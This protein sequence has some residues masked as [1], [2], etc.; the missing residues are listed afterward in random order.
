MENQNNDIEGKKDK[1]YEFVLRNAA[2][3]KLLASQN[4]S[5]GLILKGKPV[6]EIIHELEVHQIELEMQN[7]QMKTTLLAL[8]E[9]KEKYRDLYDFAPIGYLSITQSGLVLEANFAATAMLRVELKNLINHGF[10]RLISRKHLGIWEHLLLNIFYDFHNNSCELEMIRPNGTTFYVLLNCTQL[11]VSNNRKLAMISI[12]NIDDLK[13]SEADL[14]VSEEK[15]R[16]LFEN[17]IDGIYLSTVEGKFI[18]ANRALV[19]LLGY[20]SKA[21]LLGVDIPN[22]IYATKLE[23]PDSEGKG[24]PYGATFRKKD[25]S[26]IDVEISSNVTEEGNKPK[27]YQGIVR[28]ITVRKK[29]D[30]KLRY[31]S[32]HDSLTGLY[33]RAYFR[34]ELER[35]DNKRQLPISYILGDINGLKLVNDTIGHHAGDKLLITVANLL[36]KYFRSEDVVARWGG[37]EFAIILPKTTTLVVEQILER[38]K[39]ACVKK[40]SIKDLPISISFGIFTK[41]D[42]SL[43]VETA[44]KLAETNMYKNKLLEKRSSSSAVI[45][46]IERMMYEKSYE[47]EEHSRRLVALSV[48]LG[49]SIKLSESA[50]NDLAIF[51]ELHDIGKIAIP[52]A[53]LLKKDKLTDKE[54]DIVKR[55]SE[56]GYNIARTSP[57][58]MPIAEDILCHHEWWDGS[59][60]PQGL[61][62]DK[63]PMLS[64]IV[65]IVDSYDVMINGRPYATAISKEAAMK[66]LVNCSGTKFDP[67][68]VKI[69]KKIIEENY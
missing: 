11:K 44:L 42:E 37:D 68:F 21:E 51:A 45:S 26:L 64:R 38:I 53:I 22:S 1:N 55:H 48:K 67:A 49:K 5:S 32:F 54:W 15:F 7:N 33:N 16:S 9:E 47:T 62:G 63:I 24:K 28:D 30:K 35:L 39:K 69:F 27:Y 56:I 65:L 3:S 12:S 34:E 58:L 14:K 18:D 17:S 20:D 66:E 6:D 29:T 23:G 61:K 50:L 60:Y 41:L 2:E 43:K 13:K 19:E 46:A 36:K 10:A 31:L 25:G 8:E 4:K 40:Y 57:Q 52:E 59:G